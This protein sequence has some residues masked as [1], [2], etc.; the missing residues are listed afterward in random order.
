[1]SLNVHGTQSILS[2]ARA[3]RVT[4][5]WYASAA[6]VYAPSST[7]H[8]EGD[9]IGPVNIYGLSKWLGEEL[10]RLEARQQ[11]HCRFVV[12]R[13]FDLYGPRE[14]NP[15]LIPEIV[16]Q[17][18]ANSSAPLRIANLEVQRDLVPVAEAARA[19]IESLE[20]A[21]PGFT[22]IN[23]GSGAAW[24]VRNVAEQILEIC[25]RPL[26]IEPDP[27]TV[28]DLARPHL[29]ANVERLRALVGWTPHNDLRR[30]LDE[31]VVYER[32]RAE[33][34]RTE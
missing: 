34:G 6:D 7:P 9:A 18:R 17:L 33:S 24:P 10:V 15:H 3:A 4:G 27:A 28:S 14:T 23:V 5:F 20:K 11:P 32:L 29:Q 19:A 22:T 31:L 21:P 25:G 2:A 13:L 26:A 12:G 8:S 16:R 1:V 30:G